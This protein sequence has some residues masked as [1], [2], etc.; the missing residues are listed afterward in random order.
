MEEESKIDL[1]DDE[2]NRVTIRVNGKKHTLNRDSRGG[3][4]SHDGQKFMGY[5][6]PRDLLSW[7]RKDFQGS[8]VKVIKVE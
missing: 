8:V 1:D 7:Y 5:L 3:W 6:T 4:I 2:A